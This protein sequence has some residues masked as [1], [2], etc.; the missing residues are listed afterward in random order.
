MR[1][2]HIS[3]N[4]TH[5]EC[6]PSSSISS[7]THSPQVFL[8]LP[9]HLTPVTTTFLQGD[10]QSSPVLRSTCPNH[11]NL[12]W[13]TT[14]AMLWT[15]ETPHIHLAIIR[16]RLSRFLDNTNSNLSVY[17]YYEVVVRGRMGP[18]TS[19]FVP[20]YINL[21]RNKFSFG[22]MYMDWNEREFYSMEAASAIALFLFVFFR[23]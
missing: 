14:S 13:L 9:A 11:L 23:L 20:L 1:L 6:R 12:P 4:T 3:L 7:F 22:W 15:S 18:W 19:W 16:S 17:V 21:P 8:P 5:L 10:T 2:L